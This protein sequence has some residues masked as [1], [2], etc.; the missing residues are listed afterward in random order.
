MKKF[1]KDTTLAEIL[2][3]PKLEKILLKYNLPCLGCAFAK[4]EMDELKIGNICEMYGI[5]SEKML[6]ELN[7]IDKD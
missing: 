5:D 2:K 7:A 1:T 3:Y 4:L 6:K